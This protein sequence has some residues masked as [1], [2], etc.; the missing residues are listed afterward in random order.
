MYLGLFRQ[1]GMRSSSCRGEGTQARSLSKAIPSS[2]LYKDSAPPLFP[3]ASPLS[4]CL[5]SSLTEGNLHLRREHWV[6]KWAS[7]C[8]AGKRD[9]TSAS[10]LLSVER[11]RQLLE[12]AAFQHRHGRWSACSQTQGLHHTKRCFSALPPLPHSLLEGYQFFIIKL[13]LG[14]QASFC[15]PK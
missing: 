7:T 1:P 2:I 5:L 11:N 3:P 10:G 9:G 12:T 13:S 4:L 14:S 15:K 8:H 6:A